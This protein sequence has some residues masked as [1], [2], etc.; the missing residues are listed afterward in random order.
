MMYRE[1]KDKAYLDQAK[2]IA[3][4]MLK[5]PNL[6][7]DLVPYWD[8]DKDKIPANDKTYSRRSLR[9]ASA[10]AI[11]A[12]ALIELSQYTKGKESTTYL[13]KAEG[14]LKSLS[15]SAY[16]AKKGTNGGY[17][18]EHSVGALPLDSEVDVPLTYADYYYVE[19]LVRYQRLL[20]G[21]PAIKI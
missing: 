3:D 1:T 21:G 5:S 16:F 4:Y 17:L 10:A 9:D 6:P 7:E 2:K 14:M 19:A 12:S 18:L 15:S 11:T 13:R 20:D 8:F